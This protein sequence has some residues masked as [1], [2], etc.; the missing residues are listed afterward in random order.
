MPKNSNDREVVKG[1]GWAD[2]ATTAISSLLS[3][4]QVG[5]SLDFWVSSPACIFSRAWDLCTSPHWRLLPLPACHWL[6]IEVALILRQDLSVAVPWWVGSSP[7]AWPVVR[8]GY[9][10]MWVSQPGFRGERIRLCAAL[11]SRE[12]LCGKLSRLSHSP[13]PKAS[14][15]SCLPCQC[16]L[17]SVP[18]ASFSCGL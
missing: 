9:F 18:W 12:N 11:P 10:N 16:G 6:W 15:F 1:A 3:L 8:A 2:W 17:S 7:I 13:H 5:F 14:H 4:S